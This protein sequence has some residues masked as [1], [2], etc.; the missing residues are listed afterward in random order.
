M[1]S[2]ELAEGSPFVVQN[3]PTAFEGF[4]L[5]RSD[6]VLAGFAE[7]LLSEAQRTTLADYGALLGSAELLDAGRVANVNEPVL[8]RF[9]RFGHR[10]DEVEYH[11]AYHRLMEVSVAAGGH[12]EA[13][14]DET[15]GRYASRAAKMFLKH[16]VEQGTSC[17]MTMTFAAVPSLALQPEVADEWLPG[18]LSRTYDPRPL[19]ASEK[20]G[21]LFGMAM[22]ERQGGSD[23]RANA[24]KAVAD[25]AGGPGAAYRITGHKWF[26]SAPMSDAFLTLAQAPGGLSCFLVPRVMP[27]GTRNEL[28][29]QRLKDKLGNRSNA[30]SEVEFRGA[31]GIL[32][33]E[34]GRGVATIIEMV[35]HTRLDCV[36]GAASLI[37]RCL[38]EALH[39]ARQR[40][41]F[42]R[43]LVDQPLM[44]NVLA[45]M[46]IDS[47]AATVSALE[48][49]NLYEQATADDD[50]ARLAR[51]ATAVVKYWAT[52]RETVVAREALECTGG[53]GY[54]EESPMARLF[55]ESPLNSIWEGSGNVQCLDVLRALQRDPG[56]LELFAEYAQTHLGDDTAAR[57]VL[58][59]VVQELRGDAKSL[60]LNARVVVQRLALVFQAA[61]LRKFGAELTAT[62]FSS[63][64]LAREHGG[65]FGALP[66]QTPFDELIQRNMPLA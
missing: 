21:L 44:K 28:Y 49:S 22:T 42:S 16:Q 11:P 27:D 37:R 25:G 59:D 10:I 40:Y 66:A 38:A 36:I 4:N 56:S 53:N 35:R 55:R 61:A 5:Y 31:H 9:D 13:W 23:V 24:T 2:R 57:E 8:H 30:S 60:E 3:Q 43:L 19:P 45:D 7:Q 52:K 20:A 29:F 18:I 14:E 51:L 26:C 1:N 54:I 17:P 39:H 41:A 62:A 33:K 46:C 48:L 12:S 15:A 32:L 65:V 47:E 64:R 6:A 34:E 63:S 50:A 58:N